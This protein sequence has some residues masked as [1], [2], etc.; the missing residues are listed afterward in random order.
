[1]RTPRVVSLVPSVTETLTALGCPPIACTRFCERP[2]LPT[3]GGTKNPDVAAIVARSPDVV[4]MND[5]ENRREDLDALRA[6][7]V[8]VIDVSPRSVRAVGAV[9]ETLAAL[10]DRPVPAPF[11]DWD[12]WCDAAKPSATPR[13]AVTFVWRRPWM[14]LAPDTYGASV[15]EI[16]GLVTPPAE[17][18][19]P[20][21]TLDAARVIDPALVLLPSEPYAFA[22]RHRDE[23]GA[24]IPRATVVDVDGRDLFWWGIR[25]PAAVSR[26]VD[27]LP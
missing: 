25:T 19:Y 15:L 23:V 17:S 27:Q 14:A 11:D 10:V 26:L 13:V 9:V 16:L 5:E 12:A 20:E 7:G 8:A 24:A 2:D 6:A 18:R 22:P 4:V 21:L 1:V 3:V